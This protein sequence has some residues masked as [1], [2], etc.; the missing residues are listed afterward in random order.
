[1]ID[2]VYKNC[3]KK[4]FLIMYRVQYGQLLVSRT[5]KNYILTD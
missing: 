1:M 3:P 2:V 5:R 4:T